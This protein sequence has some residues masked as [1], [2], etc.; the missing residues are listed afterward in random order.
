MHRVLS[1]LKTRF[2]GNKLTE[3][4]RKGAKSANQPDLNKFIVGH[5]I[6]YRNLKMEISETKTD[7]LLKWLLKNGWHAPMKNDRRLYHLVPEASFEKLYQAPTSE[8][9]M[10]IRGLMRQFK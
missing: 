2:F 9:P 3:E 4:R 7:E 6:Y 8:R 10:I 5:F 1:A